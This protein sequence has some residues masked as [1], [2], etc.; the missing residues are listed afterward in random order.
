LEAFSKAVRGIKENIEVLPISCI[1][2][3]GIDGWISWLLDQTG[4]T[5]K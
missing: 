5:G 2:G 4:Y 3:E 1:S